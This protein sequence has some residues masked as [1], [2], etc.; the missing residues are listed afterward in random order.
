MDKEKEREKKECRR[1]GNGYKR[2][3]ETEQEERKGEEK[4]GKKERKKIR[5]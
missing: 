3:K 1:K 5:K 4:G 2:L